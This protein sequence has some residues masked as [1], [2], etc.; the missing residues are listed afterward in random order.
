MGVP[1]GYQTDWTRIAPLIVHDAPR[2]VEPTG[3]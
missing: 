1:A 2:L 3:A